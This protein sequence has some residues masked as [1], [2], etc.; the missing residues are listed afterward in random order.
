M[1]RKTLVGFPL[2]GA[3]LH[4]RHAFDAPIKS[5]IGHGRGPILVDSKLF[6]A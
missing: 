2:L 1:P 6:R 4:P 5:R 3:L